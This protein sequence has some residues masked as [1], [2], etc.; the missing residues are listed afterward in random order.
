MPTASIVT[1]CKLRIDELPTEL[2]VKIFTIGSEAPISLNEMAVI[3]PLESS[4][5]KRCRKPFTELVS[6][7]CSRWRA[8]TELRSTSHLWVTIVQLRSL[9]STTDIDVQLLQ[10][11]EALLA[12]EGSDLSVFYRAERNPNAMDR[13]DPLAVSTRLCM[14]GLT[15]LRDY[16]QQIRSVHAQV[17]GSTDLNLILTLLRLYAP[18]PRLE[19][20]SIQSSPTDPN[21]RWIPMTDPE[22]SST[23]FIDHFDIPLTEEEVPK[24]ASLNSLVHFD[25][26]GIR[27]NHIVELPPCLTSLHITIASSQEHKVRWQSIVELIRPL[28]LVQVLRLDL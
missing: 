1:H 15:F 11:K 25:Y 28:P 10:F 14:H 2:L 4:L 8:I 23:E 18:M 26:H 24:R 7:V 27:H 13:E 6:Q 5:H 22:P 3:Y 19:W 9:F 17:A 12:S 21:T 16:T 20:L